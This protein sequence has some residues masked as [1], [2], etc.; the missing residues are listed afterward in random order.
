MT[1][2]PQRPLLALSTMWAV[3]PRFERDLGGFME[4]AAELGYEAIE[5]NHSMDAAQIGSILG[6]GTLPVTGVSG[7]Q[8]T[9][10]VSPT[11]RQSRRMPT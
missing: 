6:H 1:D 4:R 2:T 10:P 8:G 9:S 7:P 11:M 5:I 3:Q